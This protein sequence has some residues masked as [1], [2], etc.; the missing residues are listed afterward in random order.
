MIRRLISRLAALVFFA[1]VAVLVHILVIEPQRAER[2]ELLAERDRLLDQRAGL[3]NRL[4]ALGEIEPVQTW[5]QGST[6]RAASSGEAANHLQKVVLDH[7]RSARL[8][9]DRFGGTF[10]PRDIPAE[11]IGLE[12]EFQ[13]TLV[14]LAGFLEAI[15]TNDPPIAVGSLQIRQVPSGAQ[16]PGETRVTVRMGLWTLV[17]VAS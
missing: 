14:Q 8:D 12:I 7:L 16:R 9:A 1:A 3:T 6:W 2:T 17:E 15:E 4:A 11:T 5:P 10:R 13:S